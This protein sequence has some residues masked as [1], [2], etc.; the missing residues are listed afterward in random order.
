MGAIGRYSQW[1]DGTL[2]RGAERDRTAGVWRLDPAAR[3]RH[4][5]CHQPLDFGT[6]NLS[7]E[8][9]RDIPATPCVLE[10]SPLVQAIMT[11]FRQN[12]LAVPVEAGSAFGSGAYRAVVALSAA[13]ALLANQ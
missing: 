3:A 5:N 12:A 10:L 4:C 8:W 7:A 2:H 13:A 11:H 6:L 9:S 1:P